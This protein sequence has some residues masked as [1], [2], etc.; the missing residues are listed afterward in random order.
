MQSA[1]VTFKIPKDILVSLSQDIQ[2][3]TKLVRLSITLDLYKKHKL[4]YGKA[5]E[6]ANLSQDE[7][8]TEIDRS[9]IDLDVFHLL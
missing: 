4:S 1:D 3:F 6:L 7:F 5:A 8:L 2:E 9:E